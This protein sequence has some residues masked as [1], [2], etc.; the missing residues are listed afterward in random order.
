MISNLKTELRAFTASYFVTGKGTQS[1]D[2]DNQEFQ[3]KYPITNHVRPFLLV[4]LSGTGSRISDADLL[5]VV[6][7]NGNNSLYFMCGPPPMI[8]HCQSRLISMGV[9]PDRILF[10]KWW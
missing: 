5:Q 6:H 7:K 1:E 3:S 8:D 2:T 10:E 4:R 9:E